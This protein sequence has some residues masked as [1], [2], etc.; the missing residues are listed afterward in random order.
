LPCARGADV[1]KAD[2]LPALAALSLAAAAFFAPASPA[3]ADAARCQAA[4][5]KANGRFVEGKARALQKCREQVVEGRLPAGIDCQDNLKTLRAIARLRERLRS[6]IVKTCGGKD[7][8]CGTP[9][10]ES[11]AAAG[12]GVGACPNFETGSCNNPIESCG[13]IAPCLECIDDAAVDEAIALAYDGFKVT[14]PKAQKDLNRCQSTMGRETVRFLIA[15]S[16]ALGR[17]WSAVGQGKGTAPCPDPGDGKAQAAIDAAAERST[18]AICKAC[19]GDDDA[20]GTPD[21]R[22]LDEI[23][24]ANDCSLFGP[25]PR[26]VATLGEALECLDCDV[27]FKTS[28]TAG[29]AAPALS[30][31]RFPCN[32]ILI[33]TPPPDQLDYTLDANYGSAALAPGF[34][35]DPYSVGMTAGGPVDVSY[36]GG[37][38]TGFATGAPDFKIHYGTGGSLLRLYFVASSG[39]STLVVNDPFGNFYCVDDSFGT[40]NPTIDFNNAAGGTY[41]LWIGSFSS[42]A[43]VSGTFFATEESANHP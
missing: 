5:I 31:S 9:D 43:T 1:L 35:P 27:E 38:C 32:E 29:S 11:L 39:D 16:K 37:S 23:G 41:D 19:G 10:D 17:C 7:H 25:C 42:G 40:P 4:I 30:L 18:Q 26:P 3:R 36:L 6:T 15:R 34:S 24:F 20:C 8:T 21:D 14:D 12:W 33:D 13:D 22:S 28:C 2:L